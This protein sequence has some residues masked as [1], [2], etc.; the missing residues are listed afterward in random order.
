MLA[1]RTKP[2]ILL[3][4]QDFEN[5]LLAKVVLVHCEVVSGNTVLK[6]SQLLWL[7]HPKG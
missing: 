4:I 1:L 5:D 3:L 6:I 2:K 7:S